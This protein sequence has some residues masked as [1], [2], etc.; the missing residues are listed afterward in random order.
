MADACLRHRMLRQAMDVYEDASSVDVVLDLPA[1]D[2]LLEALVEADKVEE[3]VTILKDM[4]EKNDVHPTED[5]YY[6]ILFALME[7]CEYHKVTDLLEFGRS[8]GVAF[9]TEVRR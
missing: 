9:T 5:T 6:P 3:A 8:H 7:Q 4:T 1:Y 2:A